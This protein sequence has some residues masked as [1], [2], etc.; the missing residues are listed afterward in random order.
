MKKATTARDKAIGQVE[1][2]SATID[3]LKSDIAKLTE[4]IEELGNAIADLRKALF[5]ETEL[6]SAE[7]ADN[8]KTIADSDA[9]LEA[10]KGAIKVLKEFYEGAFTQFVPAGADR[11]GNTVKDTM[12]AGEEGTYHG[13]KDAA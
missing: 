13:N 2:L 6:R 10:V 5:E 4:L 3:E 12:P 8:T 11:D 9:G 1:T 7:K